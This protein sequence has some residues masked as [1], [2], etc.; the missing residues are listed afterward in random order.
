MALLD[1]KPEYA[2][3]I[4]SVD[5][6]HRSLIDLLNALHED[7]GRERRSGE[8][9]RFLAEVHARISAHFALEERLMRQARY[10][11]YDDHKA[12][13]ERLLDDIRDIMDDYERG[14]YEDADAALAERLRTWFGEHF[15]TKD[16]R[17]HRMLG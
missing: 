9:G 3:G 1:W 4:P 14:A 8:V 2:T 13:H 17:L 12:D 15:A 10:D 16:A 11:A 7:L 6:E 5:Y